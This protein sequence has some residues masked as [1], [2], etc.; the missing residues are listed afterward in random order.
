ML[1]M[2]TTLPGKSPFRAHPFYYG[3]GK[4]L[5]GNNPWA[6]ALNLLDVLHHGQMVVGPLG[7]CGQSL[8]KKGLGG[9]SA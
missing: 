7:C 8:L 6:Q 4:S 5:C 1:K 3:G 2:S 9:G